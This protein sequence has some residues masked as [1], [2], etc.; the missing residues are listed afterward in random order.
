MCVACGYRAQFELASLSATDPLF[1]KTVTEWLLPTWCLSIS[2]QVITTCLIAWKIWYTSFQIWSMGGS[3]RHIAIIWTIVESGAI[4][5]ASTAT[6]LVI[7]FAPVRQR[8]LH[9]DDCELIRQ[10]LRLE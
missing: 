2:V 3:R 6:L 10:N 8:H 5:S 9:S 7:L 1:I 4:Y